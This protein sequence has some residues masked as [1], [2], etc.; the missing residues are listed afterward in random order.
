MAN[1]CSIYVYFFFS[2]WGIISMVLVGGKA[3]RVSVLL[4]RGS[5][6]PPFVLCNFDH[7]SSAVEKKSTMPLIDPKFL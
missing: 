2:V 1:H 5:S 4:I 3:A 7:G 6:P